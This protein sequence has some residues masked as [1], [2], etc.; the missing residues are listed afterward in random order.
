ML[1][2]RCFFGLVFH[3]IE[4]FNRPVDSAPVSFSLLLSLCASKFL[5]VNE[6]RRNERTCARTKTAKQDD[7]G[8]SAE[9][10]PVV[11]E[12]G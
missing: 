12:V 9:E 11:E 10:N 4:R 7:N 1:Q 6:L 3:C 5:D 2:P 8:A